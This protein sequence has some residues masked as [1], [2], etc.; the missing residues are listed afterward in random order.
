MRVTTFKYIFSAHSEAISDIKD[1]IDQDAAFIM[2]ARVAVRKLESEPSHN[3]V[4]RWV[5]KQLIKMCSKLCTYA[6][7]V[8]SS[9]KITAN[10]ELFPT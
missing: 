2:F 10:L 3:D 1:G 7:N 4:V 9:F 5:D 8:P 6:K